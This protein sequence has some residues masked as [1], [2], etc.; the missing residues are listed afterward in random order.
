M[1][2][3]LTWRRRDGVTEADDRRQLELLELFVPPDGLTIHMWVER[4]DGSGGFG[5]VETDD[6]AHLSVGPML[7]APYYDFTYHVVVPHDAWVEALTATVAARS[8]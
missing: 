4:P 7:F 1:L 6:P 8:G 2:L 5:L 3:H